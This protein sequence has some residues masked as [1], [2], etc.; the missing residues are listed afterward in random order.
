MV[1]THWDHGFV[2]IVFVV[3]FPFIGLWS[4]RRFLKSA[5]VEGEP[6]LIR[7][8]R[9]TIFFWHS[10]L[11]LATIAVWLVQGRELNDLFITNNGLFDS[12]LTYG[13]AVGIAVG[14]M[15]RPILAQVSS[16]AAAG[17]A[18]MMQP[19]ASFLPKS[20]RALAWGL[21]VSLTAGVAE[22]IAYRGFLLAYLAPMAP[23]WGAVAVSSLLFGAAHLYQGLVGVMATTVLGAVFS[24]MYLSTGCLLLPIL[25][26][27]LINVSS[28]VTAYLVLKPERKPPSQS[29]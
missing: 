20:P 10:G 24:V 19:L 16:K 4:Y 8:Y 1:V 17:L 29:D 28:M 27:A 15:V 13:M 23:I 11:A 22:E 7:E 14:I 5:A 26:H 18:E 9:Q 12:R 6:A 21:G 3:V 2:A 25:L